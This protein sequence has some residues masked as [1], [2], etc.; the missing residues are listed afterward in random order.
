MAGPWF[1]AISVHSHCRPRNVYGDF[2]WHMD[3]PI[4]IVWYVD[5]FVVYFVYLLCIFLEQKGG[6]GFVVCCLPPVHLSGAEGRCWRNMLG[7]WGAV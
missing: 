2:F 4:V 6:V 5:M 1:L 3:F 7:M